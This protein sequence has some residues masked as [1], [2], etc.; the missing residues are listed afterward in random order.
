MMPSDRLMVGR[1][2]CGV[3]TLRIAA[4][5]RGTACSVR[6][7]MATTGPYHR[8]T[9]R[10]SP[11]PGAGRSEDRRVGAAGCASIAAAL[12]YRA[13]R[14]GRPRRAI[15]KCRPA[16]PGAGVLPG[17]RDLRYDGRVAVAGE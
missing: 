4:S 17:S 6:T 9:H 13:W 7:S 10:L 2:S 11:A 14:P 8:V 5:R 12:R 16:L 3:V 1:R 15:V